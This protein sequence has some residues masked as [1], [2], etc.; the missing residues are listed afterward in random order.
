MGLGCKEGNSWREGQLGAAIQQ[1][2]LNNFSS[3]QQIK[4]Q[5]DE[6]EDEDDNDIVH[7][8]D[9]DGDVD[10]EVNV[11]V[12]VNVDDDG[13]TQKSRLARYLNELQIQFVS[14]LK[15]KT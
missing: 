7:V 4:A 8:D 12:N 3:R 1:W 13:Q 6:D 5:N 15:S 10:V 2:H 11:N 9:V 14:E